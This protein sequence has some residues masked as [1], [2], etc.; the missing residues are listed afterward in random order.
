MILFIFLLLFCG[1]AQAQLQDGAMVGRAGVLDLSHRSGSAMLYNPAIVGPGG[2]TAPMTVEA[3]SFSAG[4]VNNAFSVN[5]W[6]DN[7]TKDH[8]LTE[9][10]KREILDRMSGDELRVHLN[11]STP[12]AGLTYRQMGASLS[13]ESAATVSVPREL[14]ELALYGN[15][16][17]RSYKMDEFDGEQYTILNAA[18]GF[19]YEFKQE[20]IPELYGGV[21]FH[22][23]QGLALDKVENSSGE[24]LVTDSLITG[25]T[26]MQRVHANRG[27]GVGFDLGGLAVLNDRW[28][29][30]ISLRQI[31]ARMAWSVDETQLV[32]WEAD[33][34]GIVVDSLDDNDYL[35]RAFNSEDVTYSGGTAQSDIPMLINMDARYEASKI[36][37]MMGS[38]MIRTASS[39]QG[40][41][42]V[43]LGVASEIRPREW[44][45]LYAGVSAGGTSGVRIGVGGGLRFKN[46][47]LSL[48]WTWD[49]G[50]FSSARGIGFGLSQQIRF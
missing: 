21:T 46:Y 48:G 40:E 3:L 5:Y 29:A 45:P 27:D 49:R 35:E 33:S 38:F 36:V 1:A 34:A 16:L 14:F 20:W 37:T 8:Y 32:T 2:K 43:E 19:A 30:G 28:K 9:S 47:E 42:G 44:L 10:D 50:L 39:A 13:L 17:N 15:Q 22:F 24:L 4:V 18:V 11:A 7:F 23:Y 25:Y 6:N 12:L 26:V 41:S 31:G